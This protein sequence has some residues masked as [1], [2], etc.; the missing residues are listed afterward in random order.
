MVGKQDAKTTM[1]NKM[2]TQGLTE[3]TIQRLFAYDIDHGIKSAIKRL[4]KRISDTITVN[5]PEFTH[6]VSGEKDLLLLYSLLS[7]YVHL[8]TR[9]LSA[10]EPNGMT[11]FY[12]KQ[13]FVSAMGAITASLDVILTLYVLLID[14]DVYHCDTKW[15]E[16]WR[17]KTKHFLYDYVSHEDRFTS[18]K[19]LLDGHRWNSMLEFAP[20]ANH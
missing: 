1:R 20:D 8:D 12:D 5:H 16:Q 3:S 4:D 14:Y 11:P 10:L 17:K 19:S 18:T 9:K 6:R 15:K 7:G 13:S 2:Q